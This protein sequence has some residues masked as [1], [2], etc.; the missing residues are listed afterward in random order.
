MAAISATYIRGAVLAAEV[1]R[2]H[3]LVEGGRKRQRS[4]PQARNLPIDASAVMEAR[5]HATGQVI[6][7]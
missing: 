5:D 4:G 1:I 3:G 6:V 2:A 7:R